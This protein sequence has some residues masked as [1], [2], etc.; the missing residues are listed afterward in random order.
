MKLPKLQRATLSNGLKVILAERHE[1][2]LAN[3]WMTADAGYAADQLSAPGTAG[4]VS[5]LMDGG[6]TTR[7]ALEISDQLAMLGAQLT[8]S[9]NLDRSTV[10]LSALQSN[11]DASLEIYADVILNPAFPE[12]DFRREQ[13]QQLATIQ[14]EQNTPVQMALR[15]IPGL[16]Y[17]HD[18]A[19]GNPLTGSGTPASISRMTREDLVN[20]HQTWFRPNNCTLIVVGDTTLAEMAPKLEKLFAGWKRGE[21]PKKNIRPVALAPNPAVYLIDKPG[22]LQSVI[23]AGHA[24]PPT[25]DPKEIAIEAMND[26]LGGN[27]SSRINLNLRE[28]KNWTYGAR[29]ILVGAQGQRPYITIAPVQLDKTKE[30]MAEIE[31]EFRGIIGDRPITPEELK[32]VQDNQ[33]LSL[34]GSRETLHEV[35]QSI[36]DLVQFGLPDDYYETYAGKVQALQT[37]DV[38]DAARTV[39]HPESMVWVVVGDRAKIE[40][41]VRAL[42]WG[43][44]QFLDS[45]GKKL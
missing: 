16:I 20:F 24:A 22:A 26:A 3:F 45:E 4:M 6:T 17:G 1:V 12:A 18:H 37:T 44:I 10:R 23:I 39:V 30:A 41:S 14:R 21:A 19:Y 9:A 38:D 5:E 36:I 11:L 32:T 2:P 33:T 35:G 25:A 15:V 34:P 29:S 27:F 13:K 31:K 7:T 40:A 28:E 43:E 42:N 8:A